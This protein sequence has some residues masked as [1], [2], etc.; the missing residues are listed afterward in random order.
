MRDPGELPHDMKLRSSKYLNNMIEQGHRNVKM[1]IGPVLG[2]K[3]FNYAATTIGGIELNHCIRT[4]QFL[5]DTLNV[6]GQAAPA[7]RYAVLAS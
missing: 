3:R 1:R 5:L 4:G 6:Q 2:F 7:S